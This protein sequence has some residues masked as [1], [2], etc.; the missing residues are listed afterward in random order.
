MNG[1]IC[2]HRQLLDWEWYQDSKMVHLFIHL[3]LKAS[4]D[5]QKYQGKPL[6]RGQLITSRSKLSQETG[7]SDREI[8]DRLIKLEK[9]NE[10][11]SETTNRFTTITI[12]KFDSYQKINQAVVQQNDQR[13]DQQTSSETTNRSPA[14]VQPSLNKETKKQENNNTPYNPPVGDA[15][16]FLSSGMEVEEKPSQAKGKREI[17]DKK[18]FTVPTVQEVRTYC[19][20]RKNG[21]DAGSFID[22]YDSVGW[23]VGKNKMKDWK[24]SVRTWERRRKEAQ[25]QVQQ[26]KEGY[27]E[28]DWRYGNP[29]LAGTS[30]ELVKTKERGWI[31]Q[32]ELKSDETLI[33][34]RKYS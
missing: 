21:I 5:D 1:W 11:A 6:K 14:N 7:L 12:C 30:I 31:E 28:I 22:H 19:E 26:K 29:F 27:P 16:E 15:C 9:T 23:M 32:S 24:A 2:L 13:K 20:E 33:R 18:R 3:I 25:P 34:G 8:R 17:P 4:Y 10:I